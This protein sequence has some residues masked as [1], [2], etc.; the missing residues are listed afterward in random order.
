MLHANL[1][2]SCLDNTIHIRE[3]RP[4]RG[5]L[6]KLTWQGA[7]REECILWQLG[8]DMCEQYTTALCYR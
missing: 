7:S 5:A 2:T 8:I 1:V 3:G 4:A 6:I